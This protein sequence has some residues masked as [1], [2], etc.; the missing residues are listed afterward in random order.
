MKNSFACIA[1]SYRSG[2]I[3]PFTLILTAPA[4]VIYVHGGK[5]IIISH[6]IFRSSRTSTCICHSGCPPEQGS[7]SQLYA[8]CPFPRN[9]LHTSC[10]SSHA[11]NNL[12]SSRS[13]VYPCPGRRLAPFYSLFILSICLSSFC[14][15]ICDS[16]PSPTPRRYLICHIIM[17]T[18]TISSKMFS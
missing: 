15:M 11:T 1:F 2:T 6:F 13:P 4:F 9:A 8:S 7:I 18:S 3:S 17:S 16:S 12:I 5:A 14:S 10:D